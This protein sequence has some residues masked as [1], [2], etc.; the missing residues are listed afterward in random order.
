MS[1]EESTSP[2]RVIRDMFGVTFH[3]RFGQVFI[4]NEYLLALTRTLLPLLTPEEL[5]SLIAAGY[6]A[7]SIEAQ[8]G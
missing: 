3:T 4:P 2:F 1:A 5:D 8:N 6:F 7:R